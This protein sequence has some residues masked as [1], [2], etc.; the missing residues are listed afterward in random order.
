MKTG[1][2]GGSQPPIQRVNIGGLTPRRSMTAFGKLHPCSRYRG[3][4]G[5]ALNVNDCFGLTA[6]F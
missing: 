5:A 4:D 2:L 6:A 3:I 1:D